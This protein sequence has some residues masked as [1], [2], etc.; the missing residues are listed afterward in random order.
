MFSVLSGI[1]ESELYYVRNGILNSYA[2]SFK[3][4]IPAS[5]DSIYFTW[6]NLRPKPPEVRAISVF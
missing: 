3:M 2:L 4:P 6:Q 1:H 5:I